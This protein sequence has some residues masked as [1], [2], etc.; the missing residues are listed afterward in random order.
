VRTY[1]LR[2]CLFAALLIF[3]LA[4]TASAQLEGRLYLDK[5]EYMAGGPVYLRFDLKNIGTEPLQVVTGNSYSFCGGYR[6]EMSSEP[7]PDTSSCAPLGS[8]RS[9]IIGGWVIQP[10]ETRQDKVLLNYEH[11]LSKADVYSIRASRILKYGPPGAGLAN[12]PSSLQ[13]KV[14]GQLDIRVEVGKPENLAAIIQP[15][16]EDLLSKDEEHQREAARVIG[17]LAPPFL[18]DTI[19][20]MASSPVTR[21]FALIGLRHLNTPRSRETLAGFVEG[22]SGYSNESEQAIKFLSEMK[23]KKYYPLLLGEANK[24][25]PNQARD[26]VLAA[27]QLGGENAM[28]SVGSL[29][30]SPNK[31]SR[32]NGVMAL[33]LT[34]SPRAVPLLID[35]LRSPDVDVARLASIGLIRLT[36]CSPFE[37]GRW[38][39]DSPSN[40]YQSWIR[41]WMLRGNGVPI[42]GPSQCG[43]IIA[44]NGA[45]LD[46]LPLDEISQS[47]SCG[48]LPNH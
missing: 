34:G 39:S 35:L 9:C 36:H 23:D 43:E 18:E 29:L 2:Q 31:F 7:F 24:K 25:E 48:A 28:P 8:G 22:N 6:I 1:G 13:I 5:N 14:E 12:S 47:I 15:Y 11:D 33:P 30:I 41:W 17:S 16:V 42:Y 37:A 3:L 38:F 44:L 21:P 26:Y 27:A 19:I 40:E 45:E 32:A 20:S 46:K 10:G 4:S